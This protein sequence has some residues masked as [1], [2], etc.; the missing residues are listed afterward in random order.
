L[1]L[2]QLLRHGHVAITCSS[3]TSSI[4]LAAVTTPENVAT[5]Q[6]TT[7]QVLRYNYCICNTNQKS[8]ATA[9][10]HSL[11]C[12]TPQRFSRV[13]IPVITTFLALLPQFRRVEILGE[14]S[15]GCW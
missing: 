11:S 7:P 13:A 1:L 5:T 8:V 9:S 14:S 10:C 15:S 6:I 3:N 12:N 2:H 4:V